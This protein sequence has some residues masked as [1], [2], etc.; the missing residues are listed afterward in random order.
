MPAYRVIAA[1]KIPFESER[2]SGGH[3]T[4]D[5]IRIVVGEIYEIGT[6]HRTVVRGTRF[7]TGTYTAPHTSRSQPSSTTVAQSA[8]GPERSS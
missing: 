8:R 3:L 5:P 1:S 6:T 4:T 2:R 7:A